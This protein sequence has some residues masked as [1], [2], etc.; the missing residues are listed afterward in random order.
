MKKCSLLGAWKKGVYSF[1][2]KILL[3]WKDCILASF[4]LGFGGILKLE[5]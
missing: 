5:I 1:R 2:G 4:I 3:Y